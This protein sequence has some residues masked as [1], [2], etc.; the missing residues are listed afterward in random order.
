MAITFDIGNGT[1]V[2]VTSDTHPM[3]TQRGMVPANAVIQG[4]SIR[5]MSGEPR[6]EVTAPPV[7][8]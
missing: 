6:C 5:N 3:D 4:D 8:T 1:K 2:H 7:A